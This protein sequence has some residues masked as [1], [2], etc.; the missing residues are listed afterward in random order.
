VPPS[1]WPVVLIPQVNPNE[2]FNAWSLFVS[3]VDIF[4]DFFAPVKHCLHYVSQY[5]T[6]HTRKS[7][8]NSVLE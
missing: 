7:S 2:R 4:E 8:V 6:K 1:R 3:H 5:S